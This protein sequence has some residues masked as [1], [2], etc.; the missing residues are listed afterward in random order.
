[1]PNT[2]MPNNQ[3]QHPATSPVE[4]AVASQGAGAGTSR[5]Q[6]PR[7]P[8]GPKN[9]KQ[10]RKNR[11]QTRASPQNQNATKHGLRASGLPRGCA[12]LESQLTAFRRYVRSEMQRDGSTTIYQEAVLQSAVRHETRA[13]LAAR[14]LRKEGEKLKLPD[15]IALLGTISSATDSRDKC[16]EKLGLDKDLTANALDVL[17]STPERIDHED[18]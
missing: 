18:S 16:L 7:T 9:G 11:K 1:M 14:W 8:T 17:Y 12:Y 6:Q 5:P 10:K 4:P 3:H 2:N 15:R 13:L